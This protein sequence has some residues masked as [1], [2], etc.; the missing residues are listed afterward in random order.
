[1]STCFVL[2]AH[3][4]HRRLHL[5]LL[6]ILRKHIRQVLLRLS[7][8]NLYFAALHLVLDPQ[9]LYLDVPDLANASTL[10]HT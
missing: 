6:H 3:L 2:E 7:F 4:H 8:A 9:V 10:D 1:M 5:P